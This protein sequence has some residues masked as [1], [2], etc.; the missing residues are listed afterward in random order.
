MVTPISGIDCKG[1]N[2][3][4]K[5]N[6][7]DALKSDCPGLAYLKTVDGNQVTVNPNW[8]KPIST[9]A[10]YQAPLSARL[11]LSLSF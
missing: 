6:P 10:A 5:S 9:T 7:I 3:A 1:R 11:S 2:S 8:G 4:G